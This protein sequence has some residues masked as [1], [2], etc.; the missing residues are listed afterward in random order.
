[1]AAVW[2]T[3]WRNED[4]ERTTTTTK[5]LEPWSFKTI[6]LIKHMEPYTHCLPKIL[7]WFPNAPKL[8]SKLFKTYKEIQGKSFRRGT[9]FSL[10]HGLAR[11]FQLLGISLY[12]AYE[13]LASPSL[14][15]CTYGPLC[16][17][18]CA[19]HQPHL[20]YTASLRVSFW[21]SS[22]RVSLSPFDHPP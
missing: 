12:P 9:Y 1:M 11:P 2:K 15:L 5:P 17:E 4:H 6:P 16:L 7:W 19:F 10:K 14:G 21:K 20:E 3:D 22:F 8:K 18:H 13:I